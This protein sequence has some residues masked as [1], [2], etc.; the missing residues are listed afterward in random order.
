[1]LS[2]RF[3]VKDGKALTSDREAADAATAVASI[4]AADAGW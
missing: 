4:L 2:V 3:E 1:M